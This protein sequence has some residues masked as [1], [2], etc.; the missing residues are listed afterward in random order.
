MI[1]EIRKKS[2][3]TQGSLAKELGV[4]QQAVSKWENGSAEPSVEVLIKLSEIFNCSID[5]LVKENV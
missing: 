4:S 5:E 2:G 3:Y 1:K